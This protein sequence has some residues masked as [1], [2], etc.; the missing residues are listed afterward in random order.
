LIE[1]VSDSDGLSTETSWSV[2]G[3]NTKPNIK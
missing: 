2:A 3:Y 1:D